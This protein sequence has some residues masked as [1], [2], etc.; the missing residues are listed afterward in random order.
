MNP[1]ERDIRK[2]LGVTD[3]ASNL[4]ILGMDAH[5]DWDWLNTFE[6]LVYTGNNSSGTIN[7]A[8]QD[9]INQAWQLMINNPVSAQAPAY[10]YSV[11]EMGFLRAALEL[12]PDLVTQF[13][14]NN[15]NNQLSIEGGGI[16]SPDNLLPHGEAFIRNYLVGLAWQ[17][18]TL[19]LPAIYAYMPDDF[20]HDAQL[21]VMIEAMGFAGVSFSRIPG[22]WSASQPDKPVKG[23]D[24]LYTYL[25]KH[26]ADFFW[27]ANDGSSVFA[28][29]EQ[30]SYS[31]GTGLY[32]FCND[33]NNAV[34]QVGTYLSYNQSS[35]PS[36]YIYVPC[37]NDFAMP[38][39][40]LLQI[41]EACNAQSPPA[42]ASITKV[43]V[44]TLEQYIRLVMAWAEANPDVLESRL[45]D[46]TPY[47]TGFYASR[48]A[49]K[50][51]HQATVRAL[52][53]AEVLGTIANLLQGP[54]S[55]AWMPVRAA[56][57]Q[58][59]AQGWESLLPS[60]HH[61]YITGTAVDSVYTEE[62]LPLLRAAQAIAEG[63]RTTAI[64]EIATLI[65]ATPGPNETPVVV[66]NQLGFDMTGL[67]E[68]PALPGLTVQSVR[69]ED[70]LTGPVQT[71]PDGKLLFMASAPS[72]GYATYYLSDQPNSTTMVSAEVSPE[73]T[74]A[75]MANS[76]M[77][78]ILLND[79]GKGCAIRALHKSDGS[80]EMMPS[81]QSANV[82]TFYED[83]GSIYRFG[84]ETNDQGLTPSS[85]SLA[86]SDIVVV[87]NGPLRA[88]VQSE[89]TFTEGTSQA[90]YT[91][92]YSL[93]A[94][95]PFL[96][97][98][99]TGSVPLPANPDM[100]ST[101][102]AVMARFPFAASGGPTFAPVDG[103]LRGTPYHWHDLL[104]VPYWLGPTFQ[105]AHHFVVPSAGGVTLGAL[106]HADVPAWAID[107]Q[108]AMI[109]CILRNSPAG[110]GGAQGVDFGTHTRR[111]ALRVPYGLQLPPSSLALFKESLGYTTPLRGDYINV[112]TDGGNDQ[113]P[114]SV[115]FLTSFSLAEITGG[116]AI[117]M[118]AKE[119]QFNPE[120]MILRLYQ[121]SNKSQ[122]VTLSLA[123]Y[124]QATQK[125][126]LRVIPVTALE[127][128]IEGAPPL[129]VTNGQV[130]FPMNRALITLVIT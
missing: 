127:Q 99:V 67:V 29:L 65:G 86:A 1:I 20:G 68:I 39:P 91:M 18:A 98:A 33:P 108:G 60:T 70:K 116:N 103:V 75:D 55:L 54:D 57:R 120:A 11:C 53:G 10:M 94:G 96:R 121:P 21:P 26:G 19:G 126:S 59:V 123:G 24:S 80:G 40:C 84:N 63:G 30:N 51:L 90:V 32:Q 122:K 3:D 12:N 31:Q 71:T 102:Y 81:G 77:S 114:V 28:H 34:D 82:L 14:K 56:R 49:N 46:P 93:V 113:H 112:P 36:P 115:S 38:I 23:G 43:V 111:Y 95:E 110:Y 50:I 15:L 47:W 52:L 89:V 124:L 117:L 78:V 119:G 62:Q 61:D 16:T 41:A 45:L 128:P 64:Q 79:E 72:L 109:G 8:V 97:M 125:S 22:S 74:R 37:G 5:M 27:Q 35:S 118:V 69:S 25:M 66:F 76:Q 85:G 105:A 9:I 87:E 44:G 13:Q 48:P 106:Y 2:Q 130:T 4:L 73:G 42:S 107:D 83:S 58:A 101:P 104:P 100:F 92:E 17:K 129:L 6:T 88:R 7:R